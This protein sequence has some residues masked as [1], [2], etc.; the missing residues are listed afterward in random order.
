M[1][2]LFAIADKNWLT[3]HAIIQ[4]RFSDV[5]GYD[6]RLAISFPGL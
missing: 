6:A 4:K 1:M 3:D 2:G 5:K